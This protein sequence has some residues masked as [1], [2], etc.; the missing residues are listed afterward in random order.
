MDPVWSIVG[1]SGAFK[2]VRLRSA[3]RGY[4]LLDRRCDDSGKAHW[5]WFGDGGAAESSQ[6]ARDD[7]V[8]GYE[9]RGVGYYR[10][11]LPNV[12][13]QEM[14]SLVQ[15]QAESHVPLAIDEMEFGWQSGSERNGKVSILLAAGRR[16]ELEKFAREVSRFRPARILLDCEGIV[17]VWRELFGGSDDAAVIVDIG[18]KH[19]RICR[20]DHGRLSQAIT[21]DVGSDSL[22][23][24]GALDHAPAEQLGQDIRGALDMFG[25]ECAVYVLADEVAIGH[26]VG[27]YLAEAGLEVGACELSDRLTGAVSSDEVYRYRVPIGLALRAM[28]S[29][30]GELGLFDRIHLTGQESKA[31]PKWY[32]LKLAG[33]LAGLMVIVFLLI[34]YQADVGQL[35]RYEQLWGSLEG[36]VDVAALM[37][38]RGARKYIAGS[39][40]DMLDL[41]SL[42]NQARPKGMMLDSIDFKKGRPVK[43]SGVAK[44]REEMFK[45]QESL[46]DQKGLGGVRIES[47]STVDEKKKNIKFSMTCNYRKFSRKNKK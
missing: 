42:I 38:E 11:S 44:S 10:F 21:V 32:S 19:T 23:R 3:P 34:A 14:E 8:V 47:S 22:W 36:K 27:E 28:A 41:Y 40:A 13:P 45:F 16:V 46:G 9:S 35:A 39:R 5:P 30:S 20:A 24:D 26:G 25:G 31:R 2:A 12:G 4:E 15:L 33:V 18:D 29:D 7:V 17:A 37:R 1:R 6:G 43:I